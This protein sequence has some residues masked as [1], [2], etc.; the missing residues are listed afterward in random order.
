LPT[1]SLPKTSTSLKT[2]RILKS[3]TIFDSCFMDHPFL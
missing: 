2:V 1:A 3:V